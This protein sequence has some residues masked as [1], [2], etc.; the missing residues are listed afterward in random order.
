MGALDVVILGASHSGESAAS[1]L[2][3]KRKDWN[4]V[5]CA[6]NSRATVFYPNSIRPKVNGAPSI[7]LGNSHIGKRLAQ[8]RGLKE[9]Q[10]AR[11]PTQSNSISSFLIGNTTSTALW[12]P[13]S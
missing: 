8:K 7:E 2:A 5:G 13:K 11:T 6:Q 10:V 12:E 3:Q 4:T 1:M 9:R